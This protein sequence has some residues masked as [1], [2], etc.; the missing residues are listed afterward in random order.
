MHPLADLPRNGLVKVYSV[1]ALREEVQTV[2]YN[3]CRPVDAFTLNQN[4][5]RRDS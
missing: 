5:L 4:C 3:P 2:E 1:V